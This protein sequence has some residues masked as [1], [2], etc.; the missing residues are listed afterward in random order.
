MIICNRITIIEAH[1]PAKRVY[2]PYGIE[3]AELFVKQGSQR[4]SF[5]DQAR[6]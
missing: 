5:T 3:M 6:R 4:V 1:S 2:T